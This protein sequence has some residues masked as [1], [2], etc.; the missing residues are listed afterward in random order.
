MSIL[1]N[2]VNTI[3][4]SFAF[5]SVAI[6]TQDYTQV[7]NQARPIKAVVKEEAKLMEHPVETGITIVDHRIILPVEIE[8]SMILSP[9]DYQNTYNQIREFYLNAT[10][11]IVQT[12]AGVYTN[13]LIQSMP[14]EEDPAL[15]DTLSIAL[16]LKEVQFVTAKYSNTP[17]NKSNSNTSD[18]GSQQ[19]KEVIRNT[20]AS[21][22]LGVQGEKGKL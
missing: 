7:F 13:Q 10:L 2:I 21:M 4:P 9:N 19:G 12:R 14:H 3:L 5:D 22:I 8:L 16:S 20:M 1:Q 11:L 15:Y 17:K 18:R 6:L